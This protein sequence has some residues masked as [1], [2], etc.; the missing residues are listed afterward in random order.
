MSAL[1]F[2]IVAFAVLSKLSESEGALAAYQAL[3]GWSLAFDVLAAVAL[4]T[5]CWR[6]SRH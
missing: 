4:L 1:V 5:W 6:R 3:L 2:W